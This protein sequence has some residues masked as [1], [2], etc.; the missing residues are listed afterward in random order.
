MKSAESTFFAWKSP[1]KF[2]AKAI[3]HEF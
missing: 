3:E 2:E 1:E